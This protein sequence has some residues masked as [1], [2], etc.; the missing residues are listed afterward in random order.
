MKSISRQKVLALIM[1]VVLVPLVLI[2]CS[3][4]S[5]DPTGGGPGSGSSSISLP[6]DVSD[7]VELS[8]LSFDYYGADGSSDGYMTEVLFTS[9]GID[10]EEL[11][12]DDDYEVSNIDVIYLAVWDS[13]SE[14]AIQPGEYTIEEGRESAGF[15]SDIGLYLGYSY[16]P[17]ADEESADYAADFALSSDDHIESGTVNVALSGSIYTFTFD[18]SLADGGS[19]TGTYTG[20]V[21]YAFDWSQNSDEGTGSP[22]ISLPSDVSDSVELSQLAFGYYGA[23]GSSDGYL[24]EV[25]FTS[26]GVD[27]EWSNIDVLYLAVWDSSNEAAIEPGEYTVEEDRES[28][29]FISDIGLY[30]G[31]SYD[32]VADEES[33]DYAA[34]FELSSDDRIESGTVNVALSGSIY[35]FTFDLSLADGGSITG[36]YTGR[37][38]HHF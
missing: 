37:V 26:S 19:I 9:S 35:T 3:E 11:Y 31:Y 32:P 21:D 5:A 1:S 24:T 6:S 22:S 12:N 25:L 15:I 2:G 30:L 4:G 7:S 36:T 17:V 13:S 18:L 10:L 8:Q 29:G 27:D 33:E 23:D 20:R 34:D 14:A 16:D 28:A 38:D